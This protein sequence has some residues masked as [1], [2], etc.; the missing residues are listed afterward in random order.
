MVTSKL[1]VEKDFAQPG[2][3]TSDKAAGS[4]NYEAIKSTIIPQPYSYQRLFE[5]IESHF[6]YREIYLSD[7]R[8]EIFK[9]NISRA[10][11]RRIEE[12]SPLFLELPRTERNIC[13]YSKL[14]GY[15]KV[16]LFL[17]KKTCYFET[18][19]ILLHEK[20]FLVRGVDQE[21]YDSDSLWLQELISII[22]NMQN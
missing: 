17:D 10:L 15:T 12:V 8:Y 5:Y 19:S 3:C 16:Y 21:D 4:E 7:I 11:N 18:N 14:Q 22:E 13:L 2:L 9:D 1:K 20:L 6:D